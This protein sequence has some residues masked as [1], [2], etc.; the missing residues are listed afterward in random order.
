MA[1]NSC[2]S[3]MPQP[4]PHLPMRPAPFFAENGWSCTINDRDATFRSATTYHMDS[5]FFALDSSPSLL[6]RI[7]CGEAISQ[8][9]RPW[10]IDRADHTT[11]IVK[12]SICA[13][14]H[15][16]CNEFN[17]KIPRSNRDLD[18]MRQKWRRPLI[19]YPVLHL[20]PIFNFCTAGPKSSV[21]WSMQLTIA[22]RIYNW[23]LVL[24]HYPSF[25]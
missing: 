4:H 15:Q 24:Q 9:W 22:R 1:D 18:V 5:C 7:V 23:S 21:Q 8:T 10:A 13:C 17:P 12:I 16:Y 20:S 3:A 2:M 25:M 19:T 14:V 11:I 6:R